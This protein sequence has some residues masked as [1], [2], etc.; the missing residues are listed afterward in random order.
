MLRELTDASL[1]KLRIQ[2]EDWQDAVRQA[3]QPLI[4]QSLIRES[5]VEDIIQGVQDYGPYIVV[6][7]HVALPHARPEAGALQNAIGIAT[8]KNP[9]CFGNKDNDPVKYMFCLSATD[10]EK[11]LAGLAQLA[12]LLDNQDF[13][14]MLDHALTPEQ[15]MDYLEKLDSN[16]K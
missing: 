15:V 12:D 16:Q 7:K 4:D 3:A 8:L 5:Y 6:T 10:N 13:L 11:H 14:N 9:V 2:A 1:V